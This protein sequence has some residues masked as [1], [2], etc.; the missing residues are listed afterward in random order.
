MEC[1]EECGLNA[2]KSRQSSGQP[3]ARVDGPQKFRQS[4]RNNDLS[5]GAGRAELPF[6]AQAVG[7]VEVAN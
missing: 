1:D 7:S 6:A 5:G 4:N 3:H 2:R